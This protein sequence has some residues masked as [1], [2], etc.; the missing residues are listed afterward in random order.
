MLVLS[1]ALGSI[2]QHIHVLQHVPNMNIGCY[3]RSQLIVNCIEIQFTF[4]A[5]LPL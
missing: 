2:I 4:A 3:S 5:V 1:L